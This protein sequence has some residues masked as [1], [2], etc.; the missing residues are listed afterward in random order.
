MKWKYDKEEEFWTSGD[1]M[2][3]ESS[4]TGYSLYRSYLDTIEW[5]ATCKDIELAQ[6]LAEM[7][8]GNKK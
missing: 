8:K 3:T 7:I 6:K 4:N 2:I 1:F 5:V